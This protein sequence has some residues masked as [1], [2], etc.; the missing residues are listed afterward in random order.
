KTC[1][2]SYVDSYTERTP[3]TESDWIVDNEPTEERAGLR[4]KEC[5]VCG[6]VLKQEPIPKLSSS[7][8]GD[9][10]TTEPN[11]TTEETPKKK[12]GCGSSIAVGS[13]LGILATL[14]LGIAAFGKKKK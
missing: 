7:D 8:T 3:H 10:A 14:S 2:H 4:H 9:P 11:N 13:A 1:G 6:Q 12:K 5:T